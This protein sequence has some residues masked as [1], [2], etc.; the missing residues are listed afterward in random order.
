M[1]HYKETTHGFEWGSAKIER[2]FSNAN[3]GWVTLLI[4][5]PKHKDTEQLQVYITKTGKV[6]VSSASKHYEIK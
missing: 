4:E 5:T 3:K 1:I 6:V 2:G